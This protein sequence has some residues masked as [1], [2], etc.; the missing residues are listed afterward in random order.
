MAQTSLGLS[1][2]FPSTRLPSFHAS[3]DCSVF[4]AHSHKMG[5]RFEA[6]LRQRFTIVPI[7]ATGA[8][9]TYLT[10]RRLHAETG[11]MR[12]GCVPADAVAGDFR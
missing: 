2:G 9:P 7:V 5:V 6:T 8:L 1:G 11:W 10:R 4:M 12:N 3:R